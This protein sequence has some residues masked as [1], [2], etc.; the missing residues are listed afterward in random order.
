[1]LVYARP[2]DGRT[3]VGLLAHAFTGERMPEA[4]RERQNRV[5]L[6]AFSDVARFTADIAPLL[7]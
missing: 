1:M 6:I 7:T 5:G 4:L 3:G 2:M